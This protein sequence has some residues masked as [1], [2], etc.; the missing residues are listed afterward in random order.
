VVGA[1]V[2]VLV[3][4][5]VVAVGGL[6]L[7]V[8]PTGGDLSP[9][10]W[11]PGPRAVADRTVPAGPAT[12]LGGEL[13]GPEDVV[14][15]PGGDLLTGDRQGIVRRVA[16]DGTSSVYAQVGGRPL[17]MVLAPSGE[18]LIAN[19]GIGL[20]S[21]GSDGAVRSLASEADGAPIRFA[22]ELALS[23]D[24]VVYLSD[25]SSRYTIP[26]LGE[27]LGSYLFPDMIDGRA[28]G[29]VIAHDLATGTTRTLVA[30]LYFPNG[31]ALAGDRL[32]I[33]ESNRYRVLQHDLTTGETRVAAEVPGTPDNMTPTPD[34][35]VIV[36]VYDRVAIMDS[37]ILRSDL[38]RHVIARLPGSWFVNAD[39]PLTG[40]I[41][42]LG[43][44]GTLDLEVTGLDPAPT[45][46][47]PRGDEWVVGSLLGQP[48]RSLPAP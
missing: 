22:N 34:G 15:L 8:T 18:L 32:W 28:S 21:V 1:V 5:P 16:P 11:S 40:G 13:D 17:G 35:G 3:L 31:V 37:V 48:L 26:T 33:A 24:G 4:L 30:G 43:P 10:S 2:A 6:F 41:A 7:F 19:H 36:A 12:M 25:S 9:E 38:A 20:Q 14:A 27:G 42:V 39:D 29:R 45:S 47:L 46:V 44:D 23:A